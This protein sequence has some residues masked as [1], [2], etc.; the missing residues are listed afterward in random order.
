MLAQ[1][2]LSELQPSSRSFL[3]RDHQTERAC[4]LPCR[5]KTQR[6]DPIKKRFKIHW[7]LDRIETAV[8]QK[9][10]ELTP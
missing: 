2:C 9:F 1:R 5:K 3:D 8:F 4:I 7:V 10:S 6:R